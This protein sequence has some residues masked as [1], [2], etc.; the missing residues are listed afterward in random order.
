MI[1]VL[2]DV[3][4]NTANI[5]QHSCFCSSHHQLFMTVRLKIHKTKSLI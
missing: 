4:N 1:I 3:N 2:L 5:I